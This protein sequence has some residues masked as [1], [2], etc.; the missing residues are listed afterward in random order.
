[1]SGTVISHGVG[2]LAGGV[3][4]VGYAGG[5]TGLGHRVGKGVRARSGGGCGLGLVVG[6]VSVGSAGVN[7]SLVGL[8]LVS[9]VCLGL[10]GRIVRH[11]QGAVEVLERKVDLAKVHVTGRIVGCGRVLGHRGVS[12]VGGHGKGELTR[13]VGRGQALGCLELL[14][15][16]KRGVNG[17]GAVDVLEQGLDATV[18]DRC[19][20][21]TVTVIDDDNLKAKVPRCSG[22]AIRQP[23]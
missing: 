21:G 9:F 19:R 11:A 8:C 18:V 16:G 5:A 20:Q 1:M 13:D 7:L 2:N 22:N 10:I 6:L 17:L 15:A 12:L 23:E 14:G 4:I 3:G